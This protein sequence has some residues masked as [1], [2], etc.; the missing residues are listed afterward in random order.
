MTDL[1]VIGEAT[2][3]ARDVAAAARRSGYAVELSAPGDADAAAI[4]ALRPSAVVDCDASPEAGEIARAVAEPGALSVLV[5]SAEVFD[6]ASERPYVESDPP[7]PRSDEG[8][9][10]AAL[11]TAVARGNAR[12]V[13]VRASWL[14]GA[15]ERDII[16]E[17]IEAG[18]HDGPV[19]IDDGQTRGTPTLSEEL[20]AGIVTLL[21]GDD[22]GIFHAA[23]AGWCTRLQLAR[24]VVRSLSLPGRPVA[25]VDAPTGIVQRALSTRRASAP[26]LRD[27]R[28][29]VTAHLDRRRR[30]IRVPD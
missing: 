7:A 23:G 18:S 8:I 30:A 25:D 17:L 4:A 26:R 2:G 9:R 5:S 29:A 15:G 13:I 28:L 19:T 6:G 3:V 14:F 16:D 27:W 12:H 22:Y 24:L 1:V 11:E 21:H 10:L 20:A